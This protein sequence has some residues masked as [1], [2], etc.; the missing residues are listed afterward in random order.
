MEWLY[1]FVMFVLI[2]RFIV[3]PMLN[4]RSM[5]ELGAEI[6]AKPFSS[7]VVLVLFVSGYVFIA[8]LALPF[9]A[10]IEFAN[11]GVSIWGMA[12]RV[13]LVSFVVAILA[14]VA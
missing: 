12:G 11:T 1:A 6:N 10:E 14:R 5:R 2:T 9:L 13:A 3:A 4:V 7:I 8:G